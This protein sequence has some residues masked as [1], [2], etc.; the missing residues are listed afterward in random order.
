MLK[1]FVASTVRWTEGQAKNGVPGPLCVK[2]ELSPVQRANQVE[3]GLSPS[4]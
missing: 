4:E 3:K 1:T 2:Y